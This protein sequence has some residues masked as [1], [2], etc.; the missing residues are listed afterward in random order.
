MQQVIKPLLYPPQCRHRSSP[1][2]GS[3]WPS[4]IAS[5]SSFAVGKQPHVRMSDTAWSQPWRPPGRGSDRA[6]SGGG[7]GGKLSLTSF[8]TIWCAVV[9]PHGW[10]PH[11]KRGKRETDALWGQFPN[12]KDELQIKNNTISTPVTVSGIHSHS[13]QCTDSVNKCNVLKYNP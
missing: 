6:K 7:A 2:P 3:C 12:A 11:W 10:G 5:C 1:S 13:R 9:S 8:E 4:S